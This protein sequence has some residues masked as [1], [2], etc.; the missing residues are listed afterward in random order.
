[1]GKINTG[2]YIFF[3]FHLLYFSFIMSHIKEAG[4]AFLGKADGGGF[5]RFI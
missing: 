1:M 2:F 3:L 4:G 5:D